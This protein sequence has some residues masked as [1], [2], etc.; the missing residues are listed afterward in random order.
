MACKGRREGCVLNDGLTPVLEAVRGCDVL[1]LAT[2][3]Y[4]GEVASQTKGF[5]DRCYSFLT[6]DYATDSTHRTRLTPGKTFCL[7]VTQGHPRAD[8]F[9]DIF[10]RYAHFFDWLGF[11]KARLLRECG[12]FAPG[13]VARRQ[14]ALERAAALGRDLALDLGGPDWTPP[15]D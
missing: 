3:V 12:V 13:A 4:F 2:P 14:G 8:C 6:P 10:P 11:S 1:V 9:A 5:I 7:V 15:R